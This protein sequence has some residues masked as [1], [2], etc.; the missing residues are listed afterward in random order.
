MDYITFFSRQTTSNLQGVL[1]LHITGAPC[2]AIPKL[3]N[4]A[5]QANRKR[6]KTQTND[7]TNLEFKINPHRIPDNFLQ[8]DVKD[9]D[10]RHLVF[11]IPEIIFLLSQAKMWYVDATFKVVQEPFKLLFSIHTFVKQ[12]R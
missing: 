2:S 5:R 4:L 9:A 12:N 7:P 11:S 1:L 6:Q 8:A 3:C 10:R